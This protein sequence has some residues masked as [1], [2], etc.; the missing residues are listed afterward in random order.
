LGIWFHKA[1]AG[2][3]K[4]NRME[5]GYIAELHALLIVAF[6]LCGLA[7]VLT[8]VVRL[9]RR[10]PL[11]FEFLTRIK[12]SLMRLVLE[13]DFAGPAILTPTYEVS[14]TIDHYKENLRCIH[15]GQ[16][17]YR[18]RA[19]WGDRDARYEYEAFR[20]TEEELI[21]VA[22]RSPD[23]QRL[24]KDWVDQEPDDSP[25]KPFLKRLLP[26]TS[27]PVPYPSSQRVQ[28]IQREYQRFR[29]QVWAPANQTIRYIE[30]LERQRAE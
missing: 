9:R 4:L 2:P 19:W 18:L 16:F 20:G 5:H 26:C 8:R 14:E 7:F 12:E 22:N 6:I 27:S 15:Y 23:H 13:E 21:E 30:E 1:A 28:R 10:Q 11:D 3:G 25:A 24:W 29:N 17:F